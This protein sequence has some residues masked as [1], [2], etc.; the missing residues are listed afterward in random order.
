ML[1]FL[2][3]KC[4]V[5]TVVFV[6]VVLVVH[7]GGSAEDPSL[8]MCGA[9]SLALPIWC[10]QYELLVHPLGMGLGP[11][12]TNKNTCLVAKSHFLNAVTLKQILSKC[13]HNYVTFHSVLNITTKF[14]Y[15]MI[16]A[17]KLISNIHD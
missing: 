13:Q 17:A 6:L 12:W 4:V 9:K 7:G 16:E 11:G 1:L 10:T 2:G 5:V 8:L 15:I 14:T 3:D